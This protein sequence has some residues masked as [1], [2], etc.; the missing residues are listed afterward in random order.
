MSLEQ[1]YNDKRTTANGIAEAF[2]SG[3]TG[4][5]DAPLGQPHRLIQAVENR[6][7]AGALRDITLNTLLDIYPY[8]CYQRECASSLHGISWFSGA[9]AKKGIGQGYGDIFPCVYHELPALIDQYVNLDFWC[10]RVCPMDKDGYFCTCNG[11]L[12]KI[13]KKKSP[14]I[15]LEVNKNLPRTDMAPKIHISEITAFFENDD[16]IPVMP[17]KE[18]DDVSR[19]IGNLIADEIQNG[20]TIQLGIGAIPDAVG[21][22]LMGKK[23]LGIHTELFTD[24]MVDLI[25]AGVVDNSRKPINT[26]KTVATF[27]MGSSHMYDFVNGNPDVWFLPVD[28]VNNPVIIAQHPNMISINAALEVDFFGQVCAESIGTVH[29][30]GSGGQTDFVKGAT[31]SKGG[32]SF[33]A[34]HSTA[35]QGKISRIRPTLTEGAIVTTSKN[36]VDYIVT[37]YGIAKLRGKSLR[38]RVLSLISIAHPK[39]R[40]ELTFEAKR[41]NIM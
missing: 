34:F 19:T 35:M 18:V 28:Q 1:L 26:G 38:Q 6:I 4:F 41:R 21:N 15:F 30:S 2:E 27:M 31:H 25:E 3:W 8:G 37:E 24:S 13:L 20:S 36:D 16:P 14:H 23:N 5:L 12:G 7:K 40:E 22:A 33:I 10:A 32:K 17:R 29:V 11:S 39:F 9:Y